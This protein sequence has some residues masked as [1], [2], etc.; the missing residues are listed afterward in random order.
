M[1]DSIRPGALFRVEPRFGP[2]DSSEPHYY[3]VVAV[4]CQRLLWVPL[5]SVK[6]NGPRHDETCVFKIP[7]RLLPHNSKKSYVRYQPAQVTHLANVAGCERVGPLGKKLLGMWDHCMGR[8]GEYRTP[9][10]CLA[11]SMASCR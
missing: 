9:S 11:R 1:T 6:K 8:P 10:V 3:V 2:N 5:S 7:G 4:L